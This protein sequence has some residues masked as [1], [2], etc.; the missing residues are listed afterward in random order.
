MNICRRRTNDLSKII[1][2]H[3]L[4]IEFFG[5]SYGEPGG[6]FGGVLGVGA[7]PAGR[8]CCI[9]FEACAS[10]VLVGGMKV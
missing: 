7:E 3:Y 5:A 2:Y 8:G 10:V 9:G 6:M 4:F 1:L